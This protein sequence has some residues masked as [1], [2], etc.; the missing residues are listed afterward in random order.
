MDLR[1]DWGSDPFGWNVAPWRGRVDGALERRCLDRAAAIIVV[2]NGMQRGLEARRPDLAGRVH[3]IPNGF[4]ASDVAG[5]PPRSIP[6]ADEPARFL[7]AGRLLANQSVGEFY[8][9]FGEFAAGGARATIKMVG[10]IDPTHARAARDSIDPSALEI[11][12]HVPH[13]EAIRLM[14]EA[15]VL[16]VV[17]LGG[18]GA[19]GNMTGKLYEYLATRRPILLVGPDG[20]AAEFVRSTAAGVVATAEGRD[21][22]RTAIGEAASIA[23]DRSFGGA[24][25]SVLERF[26]RR[27]LA[28]MW[29]GLLMD[30]AVTAGSA[31]DVRP[32]PGTQ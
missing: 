19:G 10:Q 11:R 6:A 7:F 8:R 17:I 28:N 32:D 15:H 12:D 22:L 13:L 18:A 26:D 20:E 29:S 1:D 4:D 25:G 9:A 27:S 31:A 14:A 30:V 3:L 16:V 21:Q 24:V 2:S 5:F 23:R